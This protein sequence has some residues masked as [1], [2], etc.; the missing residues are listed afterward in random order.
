[1]EQ[2][3][4]KRCKM[5]KVI[6][7][8][9]KDGEGKDVPEHIIDVP[10]AEEILVQGALNIANTTEAIRHRV[11]SHGNGGKTVTRLDFG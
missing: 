1:M 10:T 6:V 3:Y 2:K 7:S 8:E 4:F 9:Y 11:T 5:D